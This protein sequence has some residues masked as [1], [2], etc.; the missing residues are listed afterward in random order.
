MTMGL[1]RE[2]ETVAPGVGVSC[3]CPGWV[4]T[5][6]LESDRNIPEWAAPNALEERTEEQEASRAFIAEAIQSG[7]EPDQV[8]ELVHDAIVN[9][10]FWIFTDLDM[11]A[12]LEDKHAS[13]LENRNPVPFN[14]IG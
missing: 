11:V 14:L 2:L 1:F 4:R 9:R 5:Q 7:M 10:K 12:M 3:L 6:I 8:A 13:I